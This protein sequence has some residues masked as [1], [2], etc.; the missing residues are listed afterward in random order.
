MAQYDLSPLQIQ[1]LLQMSIT[2]S[3]SEK[4]HSYLSFVAIYTE[5]DATIKRV[6]NNDY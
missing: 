1:R 4:G 3:K 2:V 6:I 5:Y